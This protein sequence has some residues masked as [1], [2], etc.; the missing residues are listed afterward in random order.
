MI[1]VARAPLDRRATIWTVIDSTL[2]G[3]HS[4][5]IILAQ[6]RS[7]TDRCHAPAEETFSKLDEVVGAH[8]LKRCGRRR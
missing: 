5:E 7:L 3:A 2:G 8:W 4:I 1:C 6:V